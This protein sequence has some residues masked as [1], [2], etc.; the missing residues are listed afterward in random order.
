[1]GEMS[2]NKVI[3]GALRRDLDR[4]I[5]ALRT[6]PPGD[7]TRARQLEAAWVNFDDQLRH[8]HKGEHKTAWPALRAVGV[9]TEV[10]EVMDAEH[11]TMALALAE[12]RAAMGALNRT[13]GLEESRAALAAFQRLQAVTVPHLD[14]EESEIEDVYLA[15]RDSDEIK[16]MN[17]AFGKVSPARGGRFFAWL[18]DGASA[19]ERQA[20]THEVPRPVVVVLGGIFGRGYR[21]HVATVWNG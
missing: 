16:A 8:H 6:F 13:A 10:L 11:E 18:L 14:H 21:K 20:V 1:M 9:T 3:H 19:D 17:R 2:M 4:F 7:L 12:A 5:A 15:H